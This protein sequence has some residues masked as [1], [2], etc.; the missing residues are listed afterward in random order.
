MK[1]VILLV[2]ISALAG[3]GGYHKARKGGAPRPAPISAP[4]PITPTVVGVTTPGVAQSTPTQV[5]VVPVAKPFASG[6]LQKAC[7]ASERKARSRELC[8]CIQAVADNTLSNSQQRMAVGFYDDPHRAQEI[9]QSDNPS[10]EKFWKDYR[11][12]GDAAER[13]CR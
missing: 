5:A 1:Q 13:T 9:R 6:P 11:A 12:Y 7:M 4:I 3:C 8:G 2:L 10:H